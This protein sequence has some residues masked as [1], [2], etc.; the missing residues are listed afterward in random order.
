MKDFLAGLGSDYFDYLPILKSHE[1]LIEGL[2]PQLLILARH[3]ISEV[4]RGVIRVDISV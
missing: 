3:G 4:L 1:F 2:L